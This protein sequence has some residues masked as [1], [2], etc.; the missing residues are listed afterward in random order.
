[1]SGGKLDHDSPRMIHRKQFVLQMERA[2]S[3]EGMRPKNVEVSMHDGTT[4][5]VAI[6][7]IVEMIK[8]LLTDVELMRQENLAE[9]YYPYGQGY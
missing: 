9:G 8:S 2:F 1:M 4:V 6:F 3:T 5:T 7:D